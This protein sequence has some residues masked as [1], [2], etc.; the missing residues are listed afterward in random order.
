MREV[1]PFGIYVPDNARYMLLGSFPGRQAFQSSPSYDPSYDWFYRSRRSQFWSMLEAVYDTPLG[2]KQ[3][4]ERLMRELRVALGDVILS[5]R[6]ANNTN[7]DTALKDITYNTEG[8]SAVLAQ[9]DVTTIYFTSSFVAR[10]FKTHFTNVINAYPQIRYVTLP[11]PSPRYA[12]MSK[13]EKVRRYRALLPARA[14][15][16]ARRRRAESGR[17]AT[18][19]YPPRRP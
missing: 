3:E 8:I 18:R 17:R 4:Q 19:P 11:S 9:S 14:R 16:R 15:G 10:V 12:N 2:T 6:R 5:C 7:A 1:H 13:A